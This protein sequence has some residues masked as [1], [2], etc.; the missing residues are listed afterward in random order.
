MWTGTVCDIHFTSVIRFFTSIMHYIDIP[1]ISNGGY[2]RTR[3]R[4][5]RDACPAGVIR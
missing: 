2:H 4:I 1:S 5:I 3:R